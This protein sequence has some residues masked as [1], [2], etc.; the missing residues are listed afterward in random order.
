MIMKK[1]LHNEFL[2]FSSSPNSIRP[3][4]SRMMRWACHMALSDSGY[5]PT[6]FEPDNNLFVGF[7]SIWI[8]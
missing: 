6:L 8:A 1:E 7:K 3:N 2:L 4:K 5:N